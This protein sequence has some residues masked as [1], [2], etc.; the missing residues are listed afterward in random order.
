MLLYKGKLNT[1]LPHGQ[2]VVAK[3]TDE[4]PNLVPK[5]EDKAGCRKST[6]RGLTSIAMR[7]R[8]ALDKGP[9]DGGLDKHNGG[10]DHNGDTD[11]HG[12]EIL[13]RNQRMKLA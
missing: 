9:Y 1:K 7:R 12:D 2:A 8:E 13:N 4:F 6:R 5:I 11:N 10:N 3:W